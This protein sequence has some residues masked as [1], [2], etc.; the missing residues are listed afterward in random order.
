[1]GQDGAKGGSTPT[2][3]PLHPDACALRQ[4]QPTNSGGARRGEGEGPYL[5]LL[6]DEGTRRQMP[7][8]QPRPC[9][10]AQWIFGCL[11]N[12]RTLRSS[13]PQAEAFQGSDVPAARLG[14]T[15]VPKL[16]FLHA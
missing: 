12:P 13:L 4:S 14:A 5:S 10:L 6:V 9:F 3:H 1:M 7:A 11:P 2:M 8:G 15:A 16:G